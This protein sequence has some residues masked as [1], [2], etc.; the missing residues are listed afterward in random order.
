MTSTHPPFHLSWANYPVPQSMA[1]LSSLTHLSVRNCYL[2]GEFPQNIF[3]LPN[4]QSIDLSHNIDL[5]GSLPEFNSSSHLKSLLILRTSFSGKL[6]DSIGNLKSLNVLHLKV[7]SFSGTVPSSLW[8]LSELVDVDLF[9]NHFTGQLPSTLGKLAKL[10]SLKLDDNEFSGQIPSSLGNLTKLTHFSIY[11]NSFQGKFPAKLPYLIQSL[12]L[13]YNK[14]TGSIPSH[15]LNLTFLQSLDLSNCFFSGVIPSYLFTVPSLQSLNLGHNQFTDLDISNSSKIEILSLGGNKLNGAIPSSISKLQKLRQLFLDSNN[16]TGR[17]DFGIFSELSNLHLLDL[18]YNSHLSQISVD[19]NSTLPKFKLLFLT[20]CNISEFP[21]FLKTQDELVSL[22]LSGNRIDS[23]IPSW[24]FSV[25]RNTLQY[26][27]LSENLISGWEEI[28]LTLPWKELRSLHIRSNIMQGP[29]VVPPMSIQ[30]FYISNNSLTGEID[31]LFCKLSNLEALDASRNHLSG[32]I[33]QCLGSLQMLNLRYNNFMG[34]IPQI[35]RDE[36]LM[37]ILDLSHNQLQGRI[38]RSLIKCKDLLV[39]NLGHN[40]ISDTFPFWL[41]SL[42]KLHIL[43]LG[44]NKLHGPIWHAHNS[45]SFLVLIIIDIS[46]ND[47]AG[48][49]PSEYFR[50]WTSMTPDVSQKYKSGKREVLSFMQASWYKLDSVTVI[51]KGQQMEMIQNVDIFVSIDL[52]CNKFHGE[53]PST[54]WE[55]QSLVMLNLSNNNFTGFIPSSIGNLRQL[56]SLDLSNNKLSGKIPQQL[57]S[58]TFL[59]YLNLS[60]N[61]LVGPIPQGGQV[62]TFQNSSFEG[63]LGLCDFPLSRKCGTPPSTSSASDN[64]DSEKS[65]SI[66][67]FGW[68]VVAVGYGCGLLVGLVIGHVFISRRPNLI[69]KIFGLRVERPPR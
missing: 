57:T 14:L 59:A 1:N 15:N 37:R 55:L 47:F 6:P 50:N 4:I 21:D 33:P 9:H 34:N 24:F 58:L 49:I 8:N 39:L 28:P 10:T 63:N 23:L 38:P 30:E 64:H 41:Q 13:G 56:Q 2:Y 32:T 62:W 31:S 7:S 3:Q 16:F 17:V 68:K 67:D 44:S 5:T 19:T 25:G 43:I 42:P 53:I 52:S 27:S 61:Q 48:S 36:S 12:S 46:H 66:F 22:S 35:C 69:F 11:Y 45:F 18:S 40:Q 54:I 51:N 20:S 65:D 29:L 60:Q 26:L